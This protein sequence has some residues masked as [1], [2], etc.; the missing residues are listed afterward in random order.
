MGNETLEQHKANR[1]HRVSLFEWLSTG[2]G[3]MSE[4][5]SRWL[6]RFGKW[7]PTSSGDR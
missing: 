2:S 1:R 6:N 4:D 3:I 5:G 7:I